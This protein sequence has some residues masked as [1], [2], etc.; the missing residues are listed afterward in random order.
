MEVLQQLR[1]HVGPVLLADVSSTVTTL[2]DV[3]L[4]KQQM[5]KLEQ[6]GRQ[7]GKVIE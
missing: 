3:L 6:Q 1:A 5:L 4:Q 2:K 7:G